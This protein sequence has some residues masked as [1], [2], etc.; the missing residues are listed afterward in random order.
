[1]LK[2]TV[3]FLLAF[4]FSAVAQNLKLIC[5]A[6]HNL[7]NVM[8][9]EIILAPGVKHIAIGDY[10]EFRF[11]LS[12]KGADI[13]EVQVYNGSEP[14]RIYATGKIKEAGDFVEASIW[15]RDLILDVRCMR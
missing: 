4:S 11:Y 7:D 12:D 8:E 15:N 6:K 1:M 2:L 3:F 14:S 10:Q 9:K 13:I 5:T